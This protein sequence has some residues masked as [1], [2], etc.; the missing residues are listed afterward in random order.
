MGSS[1]WS[2]GIQ[3]QNSL[4]EKSS[5]SGRLAKLFFNEQDTLLGAILIGDTGNSLA[6]KKAITAG[7]DKEEARA[8]F[9]PFLN[10]DT[11]HTI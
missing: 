1:I 8:S 2:A 3:T 5:A 6:L 4:S 11:V 7:M 9:F 10:Q